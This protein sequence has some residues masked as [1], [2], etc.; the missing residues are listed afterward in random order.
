MK[1]KE[2]GFAHSLLVFI[3]I[4]LML[5]GFLYYTYDKKSKIITETRSEEQSK[6]TELQDKVSKDSEY[7]SDKVIEQ[8]QDQEPEEK[9][10]SSWNSYVS[11]RFG[12]SF[13][14]PG[15]F[16]IETTYE[17][18]YPDQG[19]IHIYEMK[20]WDFIT[21]PPQP[22]SGP[23]LIEISAYS[24][25]DNLG[26][27]GWAKMDTTHSNYSGVHNDFN[28]DGN[29]SIRYTWEGMG[30]GETVLLLSPSKDYIISISMLVTEDL[31]SPYEEIL[32]SFKFID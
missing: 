32:K 20:Y 7:N 9:Y 29:E 3:L 27:L 31:V 22:R 10:L 11:E 19:H 23:P 18:H 4:I 21:G 14:N 26:L 6:I 25:K 17:D 16:F 5:V 2:N 12:F 8:A 15:D 13:E 30:K 24:D 1:Y 28:V